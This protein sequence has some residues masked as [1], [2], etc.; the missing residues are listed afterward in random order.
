MQESVQRVFVKENQDCQPIRIDYPKMFRKFG[1][2][3]IGIELHKFL[4]IDLNQ[5]YYK[6]LINHSF[7]VKLKTEPFPNPHCRSRQF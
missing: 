1:L 2:R 4:S 7:V 6:S 5:N 3:I